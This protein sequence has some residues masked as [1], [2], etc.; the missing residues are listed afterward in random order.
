MSHLHPNLRLSLATISSTFLLLAFSSANA[1]SAII[2]TPTI[3]SS[4]DADDPA[5]WLNP[6]DASKSLVIGSAKNAGLRVYDLAG[7][8]LQ[9]YLPA[10]FNGQNSR[11][12]NVDVQ[13]NFKMADGSRA[14]LAVFTDRGQDTLRVFKIDGA[15]STPLTEISSY[16]RLFP[17]AP[18]SNQST[19][20]GLGLWRDTVNDKLYSLVAQRGGSGAGGFEKGHSVAQFEMIANADGTVGSQLV[21]SWDLPTTYKGVSLLTGTDSTGSSYSPQSEGFVVDQQTGLAYVGQED[22]GI[23]Q[24]D[25]KSGILGA[26]PLIETKNFN[27]NSPITPDVEGL[28]IRYSNNGDGVILASSQGDSTF[29]AFDRKTFNYLGS[30][31]IGA[32]SLID[33]VQHSDGADVTSFGLPGFEDGLFVTQDGEDNSITAGSTNFKYVKW[34]DIVKDNAFLMP[35]TALATD[36][37]PRNIAAVPEPENYALLLTGLLMLGLRSR[38]I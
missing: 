6:I 24:I 3:P 27:V 29:T 17:A 36:F 30:F 18:V 9:S 20:Y 37:D 28:T 21:K 32:N 35:Y 1:A 31:S 33:G 15:S 14:D 23:W 13:Y 11:L 19:G 7:Q 12:N 25:L 34:G 16:N 22:V 8:Q 5:I 2:E 26:A 10:A 4:G 38:K